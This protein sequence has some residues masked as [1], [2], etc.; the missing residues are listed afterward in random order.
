MKSINSKLDNNSD[1]E[2]TGNEL[3]ITSPKKSLKGLKLGMGKTFL[4]SDS[5][6]SGEHRDSSEQ[7]SVRST[8]SQ[9][10][11]LKSQSN[12]NPENI[13]RQAMMQREEKRIMFDLGA[14]ME[15]TTEVDRYF[16]KNTPTNYI[17]S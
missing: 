10:G 12:E 16:N 1:G 8:G 11:I 9:R 17:N 4:K 14:N 3:K 7:N 2:E 15:F 5:L 6:E 13:L